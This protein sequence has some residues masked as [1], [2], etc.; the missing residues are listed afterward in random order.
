MTAD[1]DR[2]A[3]IRLFEEIRAA[4]PQLSMRLNEQ[5]EHVD[6][7]MEIPQQ[8][9]LAFAI[10]LNLQADELHLSAGAYWLR[11]FPCTRPEIVEGYRDVV[12]GLISGVY[13]I[14][15]Q[16][17]GGRAFKAELQKPSAGGWET[18]D[19]SHWWAWPFPRRIVERV[20]QNS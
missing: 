4:F 9:G 16:H 7:Y 1:V 6:L 13:R 19:M 18:I 20:L 11:W 12:H 17:R 14:R 3:M 5:H 8:P 2:L 10:N 15:E